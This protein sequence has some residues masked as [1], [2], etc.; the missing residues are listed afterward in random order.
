M[1]FAKERVDAALDLVQ[2]LLLSE[3]SENYAG[4]RGK[5]GFAPRKL[6]LS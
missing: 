3:E 4:W 2:N 6:L 1:A 5:G